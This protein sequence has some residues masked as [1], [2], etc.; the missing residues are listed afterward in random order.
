M[1]ETNA[2][3]DRLNV[4]RRRSSFVL[5]LLA[6]AIAAFALMRGDGSSAETRG[7]GGITPSPAGSTS[8]GPGA[9]GSSSA[10]GTAGPQT[11]NIYEGIMGPDLSP[12][13]AGVP[14]L[15]Y[16]PNG[17]PGTIEV[18]DAIPCA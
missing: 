5:I 11:R 17:I 7:A 2:R 15:V 10:T 3:T 1:T 14:S 13:V 4:R 6:G 16:V 9:S 18:I 12:K 8:A